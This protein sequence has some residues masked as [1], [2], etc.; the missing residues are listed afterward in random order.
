MIALPFGL[1]CGAPNE[2]PD[3]LA[4]VPEAFVVGKVNGEGFCVDVLLSNVGNTQLIY[5]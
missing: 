4:E 2:N 3:G 5:K 1:V